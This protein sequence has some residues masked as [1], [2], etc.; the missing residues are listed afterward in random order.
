MFR[1]AVATDARWRWRRAAGAAVPAAGPR[2][3]AVARVL[4]AGA[5]GAAAARFRLP[6]TETGLGMA[7][8]RR[9]AGAA[10]AVLRLGLLAAFVVAEAA[11]RRPRTAVDAALREAAFGEAAFGEA[12]FALAFASWASSFAAFATS[13]SFWRRS[14]AVSF[15]TAATWRTRATSA[16]ALRVRGAA[17]ARALPPAELRG[18][19]R[20][21]VA[22]VRRVVVRAMCR[23]L[24]VLVGEHNGGIRPHPD[25]ICFAVTDCAHALRVVYSLRSA[26]GRLGL[27]ERCRR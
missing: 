12:A 14:I 6:L 25:H 4:F 23:V 2:R 19:R 5:V 24:R 22:G 9:R 8:A 7:L 13:R 21:V 17:L 26:S 15:A 1:S 20:G 3:D 10:G 11:L 27:S 16:P 18:A